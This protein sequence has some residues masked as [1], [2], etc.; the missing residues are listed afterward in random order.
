MGLAIT[1]CAR[2]DAERNLVGRQMRE[3]E[4]FSPEEMALFREV[5]KQRVVEH[6]ADAVMPVERVAPTAIGGAMSPE[7]SAAWN[8]WVDDRIEQ[9]LMQAAG[10]L[11]REC[12]RQEEAL[13]KELKAKFDG[14][15]SEL[16]AL[17][18]ENTKLRVELA[19]A[20]GVQDRGGHE[21]IDLPTLPLPKRNGLHG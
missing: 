20:R 17:R 14:I 9:Q 11:S 10:A 21:V 15:I 7:Q 16:A 13:R 1:H 19:Y 12:G 4:I 6:E 5:D 8:S 18:E 3:S 2:L